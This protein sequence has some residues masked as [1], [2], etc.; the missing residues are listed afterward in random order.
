[1]ISSAVR[2]DYKSHKLVL[3]GP[4]AGMFQIC[5]LHSFSIKIENIDLIEHASDGALI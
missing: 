3:H 5:R 1:M 2:R 4:R